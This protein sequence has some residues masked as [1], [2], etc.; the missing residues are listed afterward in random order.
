MPKNS[1]T[2]EPRPEEGS[3]QERHHASGEAPLSHSTLKQMLEE[4]QAEF[5]EFREGSAELERELESELGRV[6]QRARNAEADLRE[7][8]RA[9]R[10]TTGRLKKE[11]RTSVSW[12]TEERCGGSLYVCEG[13]DVPGL[14]ARVVVVM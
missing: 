8:Q 7:M 2:T 1:C 14:L 12:V 11:V 4:L 10:E 13:V 9:S 3:G 5:D 6:E